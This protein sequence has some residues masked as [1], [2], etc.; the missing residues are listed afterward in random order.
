MIMSPD[1]KLEIMIANYAR[2]K[3]ANQG[4]SIL[5]YHRE[6]LLLHL[7]RLYGFAADSK[8][9]PRLIHVNDFFLTLKA[10]TMVAK[11]D[12]DVCEQDDLLLPVFRQYFEAFDLLVQ[13][14]EPVGVAVQRCIAILTRTK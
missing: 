4:V 9:A 6:R 8:T 10:V 11:S 14:G 5:E 2:Q 3:V 7:N 1:E 12:L 13:G